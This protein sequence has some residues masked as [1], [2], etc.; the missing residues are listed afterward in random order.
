MNKHLNAFKQ[1]SNAI[2]SNTNIKGRIFP[3]KPIVFFFFFFFDKCRT[4]KYERIH[5]KFSR[6]SE[7]DCESQSRD[8]SLNK[9]DVTLC[10]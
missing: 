8:G 4:N 3:R 10:Q 1:S 5:I 9:Y 7:S 2:V 6:E